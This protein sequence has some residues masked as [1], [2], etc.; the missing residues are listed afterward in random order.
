MKKYKDKIK[1]LLV[2]TRLSTFVKNDLEILRKH[3]DV[4]PYQYHRK[5]DD[6]L[7][8]VWA[9]MKND[10][11]FSWFALDHAA[12]SVFFSKLFGKKSIVVTGGYDV[13]NHPKINYGRF[14]RNWRKRILT[15]F[16]IK[17]ADILLPVSIFT[18]NEMLDKAKTKKFKIVY[19][20][21][22]TNKYKP[23]GKKENNLVITVGIVK[24]QNLKRK[25]IV[26]FIKSAKYLPDI[27]FVVIGK[28]FK[29]SINYL[30]SIAPK[31][32]EFTG[33]VSQDE[34]IKWYQKAKVICQLSYYE[35]FGLTPA[36]G[37]AC[38]CI[39]V[40]TKER[41]GLPEFVQDAGFYAPYGDEKATAEAIKQALNAPDYLGKKARKRIKDNFTLNKREEKLIKI[42]LNLVNKN[43]YS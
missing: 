19:N 21:V 31:N 16:A 27:R 14:M 40:V 9:T 34:L 43:S 3:F 26:T 24:W 10:L 28:Y 17:H 12:Y 2:Y 38:N 11:T 13:A 1:I 6:L 4:T 20:G 23:L 29:D 22:D 36:E 37:M 25:G 7:K 39:P 15:K 30:K 33:F 42:I 5:R 32:V 41:A 18:K 8:I 35:A